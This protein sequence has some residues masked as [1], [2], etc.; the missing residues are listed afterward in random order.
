MSRLSPTGKQGRLAGGGGGGASRST[1]DRRGRGTIQTDDDFTW[2]GHTHPFA[3]LVADKFLV[4]AKAINITI[5]LLAR[6]FE[7]HVN[8]FLL[9]FRGADGFEPRGVIT[10]S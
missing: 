3:G 5:G 9:S 7:G 1:R 10:V 6:P 2:L 4:G 8:L